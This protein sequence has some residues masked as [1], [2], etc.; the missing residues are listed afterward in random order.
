MP[1]T[2]S[3]TVY[4]TCISCGQPVAKGLPCYCVSTAFRPHETLTPTTALRWCNGIL[5]QSFFTGGGKTVWRDVPHT[6][7]APDM[8]R[9]GDVIHET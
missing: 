8:T 6:T 5:Q 9:P 2:P 7:E 3:T 4:E 1:F